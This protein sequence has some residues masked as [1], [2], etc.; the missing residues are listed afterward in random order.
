M[1]TGEVYATYKELCR[2]TGAPVLTQ[3]RVT[4]FVSELDMLG[5]VHARVKSYGRG[6]R[7]KEVQSAV[8]FLEIRRV[9]EKDEFL[10][11]VRGYRPR[12]QTTLM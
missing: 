12:L 2:K 11:P 8:P 9:L 4:D 3:R 1:T 7:T 6:G 10:A 5:L